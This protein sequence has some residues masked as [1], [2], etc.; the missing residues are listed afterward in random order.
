MV[1]ETPRSLPDDLDALTEALDDP[2]LDLEAVLSVL[3]DDLLTAIP[4]YLGMSIT[5]IIDGSPCT[6]N[7]SAESMRLRAMSSLWLPLDPLGAGGHGG[8]VVFYARDTGAFDDL[9]DDARWMFSRD[10]QAVVDR[11]LTAATGIG[12]EGIHGLAEFSDINQA[13]GVLS[14]MGHA[15]AHAELYRRAV[16]ADRTILQTARTILWHVVPNL[17]ISE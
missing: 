6:L 5:V 9:A 3:T 15:S 10:G 14:A 1:L 13:L 12:P 16:G 8:H 4:S 17:T 11:H 2:V 7:S